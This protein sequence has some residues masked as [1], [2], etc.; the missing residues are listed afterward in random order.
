MF[1]KNRIFKP[2]GMVDT[3]FKVPM[4]KHER[5]AQIYRYSKTGLV[6]IYPGLQAEV[7]QPGGF[8]S[9]GGGLVGTTSDY[10]RFSQMILNRGALDG[11]RLLATKPVDLM[12]PN[13][14]PSITGQTTTKKVGMQ[15]GY[16]LGFGI[17]NDVASTG[18]TGSEGEAFWGGAASTIFWIDPKEQLVAVLMT[19]FMP[20]TTFPLR[21]DFKRGLYQ[22]LINDQHDSAFSH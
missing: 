14:L 1:L 19:Q 4:S 15:M 18:V 2:L 17:A 6:E 13:H 22:A 5:Q 3:G 11:V 7:R 16:G 8:L 9:G 12:L 20:H 21:N 10:L